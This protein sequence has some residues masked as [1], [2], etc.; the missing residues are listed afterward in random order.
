MSCAKSAGLIN[1]LFGLWSWV[2]RRKH[3]FSRIRQVA[4]MCPNGRAHWHNLLNTIER[5]IGRTWQIRL[6]HLSAA[7][8]WPYVKLL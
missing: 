7:A 3:K 6:N 4:P 1:L 2:G 5:H 8:M